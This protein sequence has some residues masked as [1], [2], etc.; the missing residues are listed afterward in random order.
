MIRWMR[1]RYCDW[2]RGYSAEDFAS[3]MNKVALH[4][5]NPGA[6]IYVTKRELRAHAAYTKALHPM[7]FVDVSEAYCG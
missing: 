3:V 7:M 1:E 4:E 6:I 5:A 2:R